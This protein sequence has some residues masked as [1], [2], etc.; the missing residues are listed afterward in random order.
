M[1]LGKIERFWKSIYS[2]FL[3]RAQFDTFDEASERIRM[4]VK[5]YNHKR[6][7]QGIQGLCPADRF[8]EIA[9]DMRNAI[10]QGIEENV[11]EMA[12]RGKPKNP[13]Y[14][15]GRMGEQSVV[16]RAE[17][18]KVKMMVDG[19]NAEEGQEFTYDIEKRTEQGR[20]S[21]AGE[22]KG[23]E[24]AVETGDKCK[25]EVPGSSF[26]M[27]RE[28]EVI[29]GMQGVGGELG[30]AESLAEQ[31]IGGG[32][33]GAGAEDEAGG[34]AWSGARG[35]AGETA[36]EEEPPDVEAIEAGKEAGEHPENQPVSGEGYTLL[37]EDEVHMLAEFLAQKRAKKEKVCH[38][39]QSVRRSTEE[40]G[41][42]TE[43]TQRGH[44][45]DGSGQRAGDIPQDVLQV[46]KESAERD[47]GCAPGTPLRAT[48]GTHRWRE[49]EY[50]EGDPGA[51]EGFAAVGAEAAC[52]GGLS[53]RRS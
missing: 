2:E 3:V 32:D 31:G 12:L 8:Y 34:G 38:E 15:V 4:W 21:V 42:D 40:G 51:G 18:G 5:Y 33:E 49:D 16:I 52:P 1:T 48:L 36:G 44:E 9:N 50:E 19:D 24:T 23:D 11:L 30:A 37:S 25:R 6:P 22:E 28:A 17:K 53:Y 13:F 29:G 27:G 26:D 45:C 35:E 43:S 47:D 7:H 10:E 20:D 46:G 41:A 14:M 39:G